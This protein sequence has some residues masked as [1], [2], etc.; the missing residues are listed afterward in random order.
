E[1]VVHVERFDVALEGDERTAS[2]QRRDARRI[3]LVRGEELD[4]RA[5]EI[6]VLREIET[7]KEPCLRFFFLRGVGIDGRGHGRGVGGA[8]RNGG[9]FTRCRSGGRGRRRSARRLGKGTPKEAHD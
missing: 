6:V 3:T 4:E 9:R 8:A 1:Q 7:T 2:V 5:V